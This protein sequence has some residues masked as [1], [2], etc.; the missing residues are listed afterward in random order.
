MKRIVRQTVYF[1][2][3][4]ASLYI[5]FLT[6]LPK[7]QKILAGAAYIVVIGSVSYVLMLENRSPYKT[8]L[9]LYVLWFFPLGG[10]IF[11]IYSGQLQV[12]GHLFKN[13]LAY[14]KD[15]ITRYVSS[16]YSIKWKNWGSSE[17]GLMKLIEKRALAPVSFYTRTEIIKNGEEK[18]AVLFEELEKA[19]R[20]IHMEYYIFRDDEIGTELIELLLKK[21]AEGVEIRLI[22]DA[23]GSLTLSG[24]S[25]RKLQE[26][27][28]KVHSFLPIKHGFFNQ[29]LNFRNHRKIV[30]IDGHTG[31]LGGLNVG[32]E[33]LGRNPKFG[34]WRD[35]HVKMYGE[36]VRNLHA[37][38][39][40]DWAYVN[41]E[42]LF[43]ERYLSAPVT[44]EDGGVQVVAS[45][46]DMPQGTMG[47]LYY[48]LISHAQESIWIATPYFVPSKPIRQALRMAAAKGV[49]VKLLVPE[50]N[51]SIL[52]QY[53]T[54]SYFGELLDEGVEIFLYQ[55]GFLH[56]KVIIADG[57]MASIGTANMDLRSFNLNFEVN[58]F[59]YHTLSVHQL[60]A[61]FKEDMKDSIHVNLQ[62]FEKRS[63]WMRTK[64]S[65]ARLFSP[66]L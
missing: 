14:S 6:S 24:K 32:D 11:Y 25:I 62:R 57:K 1:I 60:I 54:R 22:Y 47:D 15:A 38:F 49:E 28:V 10:Y 63:L 37:I 17:Q 58:L 12:K 64:E 18:F 13:K 50:K 65:F 41:G 46:P 43:E 16:R 40:I 34:F 55:R 35:T 39:L 44:R 66:V 51:D 53:A 36:A 30:V 26:G 3:M 42:Q 19:R 56:Q 59:L 61:N 31:F 48:S 8:L 23:I 5:I 33:Y 27:G 20:F 2:L 9:W 21:A 52:T 4:T 29:K 7:E 45:G